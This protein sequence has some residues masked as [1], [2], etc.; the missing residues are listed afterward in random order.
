MRIVSADEVLSPP[1]RRK[2][3]TLDK[4]R[5]T[6]SFV[7]HNLVLVFFPEM[8]PASFEIMEMLLGFCFKSFV[9]P[10]EASVEETH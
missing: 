8:I 10:E 9:E 7:H 2:K 1:K 4:T 5:A 6:A 3:K